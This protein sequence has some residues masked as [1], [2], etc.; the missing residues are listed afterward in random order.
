MIISL[1]ERPEPSLKTNESGLMPAVFR[2]LFT[3]SKPASSEVSPEELLVAE[4]G[5]SLPKVR[6]INSVYRFW[7]GLSVCAAIKP[8]GCDWNVA[9]SF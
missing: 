4:G 7:L 9:I 1:R 8:K 3:A 6:K 5:L 2:K